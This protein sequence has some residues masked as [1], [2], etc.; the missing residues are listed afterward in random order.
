MSLSTWKH[1]PIDDYPIHVGQRAFWPL[2]SF[3]QFLTRFSTSDWF[4]AMLK[5]STEHGSVVPAGVPVESC[6]SETVNN[7]ESIK[8]KVVLVIYRNSSAIFAWACSKINEAWFLKFLKISKFNSRKSLGRDSAWPPLLYEFK[9]EIE[10]KNKIQ[11]RRS[12]RAKSYSRDKLKCKFDAIL[13]VT[14]L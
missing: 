4:F 3:R 10:V 5:I 1:S 7:T 6:A 9:M 8:Q 13:Q 12:K 14:Y 11:L 2:Y